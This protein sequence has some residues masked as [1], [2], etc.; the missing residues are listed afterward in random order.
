M[1]I[2]ITG[3]P[4]S[5]KTEFCKIGTKFGF[6]TVSM[7]DCVRRFVK[8]QNLELTNEIILSVAK[9]ERSKDKGIWAKRTPIL[10]NTIID[11]IRNIEEIEVFKQKYNKFLL[12]GIH[13]K[14]QIR[15]QRI[16]GR[17][18]ENDIK[19]YEDFYARD[20]SEYELGIAK[21]IIYS[22]IILN[23]NN[24]LD[25]FKKLVEN[26]FTSTIKNFYTI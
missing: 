19:T 18:R 11:G 12:V 9:K 13:A 7:G 16:I 23:N 26:F 6:S 21:V 24:T 2:G 14:P 10:D 22:D 15:Y 25:E 20:I 5:G 8:S 1:I 17:A 3:L 4:G